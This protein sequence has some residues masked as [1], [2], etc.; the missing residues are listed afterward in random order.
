M[1][2][3]R[4]RRDKHPARSARILSTGI[5]LSATFG[6]TSAYAIAARAEQPQDPNVAPPQG[7]PTDS[8][9]SLA[10]SPLVAPSTPTPAV[11]VTTAPFAQAPIAT[12]APTVAAA[13]PEGAMLCVKLDD[14]PALT[15]TAP[16]VFDDE[17]VP[18]KISEGSVT[19]DP[20][21]DVKLLEPIDL[22][23]ADPRDKVA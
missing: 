7:T 23:V 4:V 14:T 15:V 22:P 3:N 12:A 17:A 5:A 21:P 18:D 6:L 19:V 11:P 1:T 20:A 9:Q 8:M 10:T 2:T 13:V 16:I